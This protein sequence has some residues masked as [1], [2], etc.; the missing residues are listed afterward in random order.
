MATRHVFVNER[1]VVAQAEN[2]HE[3]GVILLHLA[4]VLRALIKQGSDSKCECKILRKDDLGGFDL[5]VVRSGGTRAIDDDEGS[6]LEERWTFQQCV[7][8]ALRSGEH[9]ADKVFLL[10]LL[11]NYPRCE[12]LLEKMSGHRCHQLQDGTS[13]DV[14]DTSV[15]AAAAMS[16]DLVSLSKCDDFPSGLVKVR[17]R[18]SERDDER[19]ADLVNFVVKSDVEKTRRVY[20]AS[21]KHKSMAH[22]AGGLRISAMDLLPEQAQA[23]LDRATAPPR[24]KRLF[25]VHERRLYVFFQHT[26]LRF[27]GYMVEDPEEYQQRDVNI[28]NYLRAE[29]LL[30][31]LE[32]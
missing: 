15:A 29:G 2:W 28:Y 4:E 7:V 12:E 13:K 24:E 27:H 19:E 3:A 8:V 9:V 18:G 5:L 10:T 6:P 30:G 21:N 26:T 31:E 17:Y 1:S 20:E 14:A 11:T 23:V 32:R 25:A 22:V 16:G